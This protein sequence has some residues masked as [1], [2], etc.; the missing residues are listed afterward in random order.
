MS[1]EFRTQKATREKMCIAILFMTY[2]G[3]KN[4]GGDEYEYNNYYWWARSTKIVDSE[5]VGKRKYGRV[6]HVNRLG[7]HASAGGP[8]AQQSV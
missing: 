7:S 5:G 1:L 4:D 6:D 8:C 2:G 3:L